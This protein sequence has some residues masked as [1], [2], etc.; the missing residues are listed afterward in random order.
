MSLLRWM[1]VAFARF[2]GFVIMILGAW[3]FF[4]NVSQVDYQAWVLVWILVS[5]LAGALGG[6]LSA[7]LRRTETI[8]HS[9]G[10]VRW[11]DRHAGE[12]SPPHLSALM[13][14][15]MVAVVSPMWP[16]LRITSE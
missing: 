12:R 15:P 14:L 3:I 8:P 9:E 4:L 1:G 13:I 11:L 5:G 6:R 10:A 2:V 16:Y 7:Q